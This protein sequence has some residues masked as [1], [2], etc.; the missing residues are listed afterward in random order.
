MRQR[1]IDMT[2]PG[3]A[4]ARSWQVVR[5]P[6]AL[7]IPAIAGTGCGAPKSPG[8]PE[9]HGAAEVAADTNG[10][11]PQ[12]W[13]F[14]DSADRETPRRLLISERERLFAAD[15][16][17]DADLRS[18]KRL[19]GLRELR[20]V[21]TNVTDAAMECLEGAGHLE[22]LTL[23]ANTSLGR[24]SEP[25]WE[26]RGTAQAGPQGH[27]DHRRRYRASE[28]ASTSA[29]GWTCAARGSPRPGWLG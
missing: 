29:Q 26:T 20:L 7:L 28:G 19:K 15:A 25:C 18:L 3:A 23:S 1:A 16:T 17:S 4:A 9:G 12:G 22:S 10:G 5:W 27:A 13:G 24:R 8:G 2:V 14:D 21:S 11:L 6:L